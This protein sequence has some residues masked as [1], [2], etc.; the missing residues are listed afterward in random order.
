MTS[1]QFRFWEKLHHQCGSPY[2]YEDKYPFLTQLKE[3]IMDT[4][5][6]KSTQNFDW[7]QI[8]TIKNSLEKFFQ[9]DRQYFNDVD[10]WITFELFRQTHGIN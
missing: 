8:D 9:G 10:W 6:S 1:L 4:F 2:V 7:Y 3:P 5:Y